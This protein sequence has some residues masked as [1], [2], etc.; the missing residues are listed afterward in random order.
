MDTPWQ[1]DRFW[2]FLGFA[3]FLV[4]AAYFL[5]SNTITGN[6]VKEPVCDGFNCLQLCDQDNPQPAA[7]SEDMVCCRTHWASGVC[8]YESRCERLREYSLYQSIELY[9][10]TVRGNPPRVVADWRSFI[11]PLLL[12]GALIYFIVRRSK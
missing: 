1:L 12:A 2:V 10:D 3:V 4:S 11:L 6:A 9:D 7:C 5:P 8:S